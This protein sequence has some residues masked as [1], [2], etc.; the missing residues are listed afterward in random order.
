MKNGA[1]NM[2]DAPGFPEHDGITL[3]MEIKYTNAKKLIIMLGH[4]K[5]HSSQYIITNILST[6]I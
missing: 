1:G 4:K 5:T 6:H 2:G 3:T